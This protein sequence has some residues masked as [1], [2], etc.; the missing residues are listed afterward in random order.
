MSRRSPDAPDS[1]KGRVVGFVALGA[2]MLLVGI[3][4]VAQRGGSSSGTVDTKSGAIAASR[5]A[6]STPVGEDGVVTAVVSIVALDPE[7]R[8]LSERFHCACGCTDM[9]LATCTCEKERGSHEMREFL[10]AL[11]TNGK[12]PSQIETAMVARFGEGALP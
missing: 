8:I 11:V 1:A 12:N 10:Q 7:A 2:L 5:P 6:V 4:F 9:L 3:A